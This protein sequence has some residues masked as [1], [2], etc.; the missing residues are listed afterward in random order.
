[1]SDKKAKKKFSR[2][3]YCAGKGTFDDGEVKC[4]DCN[5]KGKVEDKPKP[6][7]KA[8]DKDKDKV[9]NEDKENKE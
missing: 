5:G 3:L 2:C 7:A 9:E 4:V 6:K 8:K 1:M